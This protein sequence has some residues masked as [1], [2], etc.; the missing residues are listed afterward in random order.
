MKNAT[1]ISARLD[2]ERKNTAR[3]DGRIAAFLLDH[4]TDLPALTLADIAEGSGTST[5]TAF[6]FFKKFGTHGY[7]DFR[8]LVEEELKDRTPA[9]CWPTPEEEDGRA[10]PFP[11]SARRIC[12]YAAGVVASCARVLDEERAMRVAAA[13]A[14]AGTVQLAGLGSSAVT[15]Q[16]ACTKF[17]RLPGAC[18]FSPDV[19]LARMKAAQ[20]RAGDVFFA[21]S[22]SGR[23][24]V[25]LEMARLAHANGAT[26]IALSDFT[27]SPLTRLADIAICTTARESGQ[28][29]DTDFPLIQGQ[30][31]LIDVLS[32]ALS[33]VLTDA[34]EQRGRRAAAAIRAYK[35]R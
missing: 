2:A 32:A 25:I 19:I 15:A 29:L 11:E 31:T 23:T 1:L 6:R 22:S 10:L 34:D 16:Y 5:I 12:T 18:F 27:D 30:I 28:Y 17:V 8:H 7:R 14:G 35:T 24:T 20:L 26:V 21:V 4:I 13:L 9:D 3:A 33:R